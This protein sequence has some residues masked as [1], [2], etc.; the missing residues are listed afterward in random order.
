[1]DLFPSDPT[2]NL[3]P[4]DGTVHYYGRVMSLPQA[5]QFLR[6]LL[7]S[8]PWQH[9]EAVIFGRRIVTARKV[10]WFGDRDFSYTYSGT[11]KHALPWTPDLLELKSLVEK[12][13]G[14]AFNSCLLNLYHHGGEGMAWHSDDESMLVRHAAIASVS[15]GAERR[16]AFKH[17]RLPH[18]AEIVLEHGSLLVMRDETQSHW[19]H[20]IPKSTKITAPRINLTFRRIACVGDP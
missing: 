4:C 5:D 3:L 7:E 13:S 20:S 6:V 8:I 9:D 16:F 19:L 18:K 17:K 10:A 2:I 12:R 1:M 14:H 15:L 11:T